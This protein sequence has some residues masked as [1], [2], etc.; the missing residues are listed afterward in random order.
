MCDILAKAACEDDV[1]CK[2]EDAEACTINELRT[3][4]DEGERYRDIRLQITDNCPDELHLQI[5]GRYNLADIKIL[6][7]LFA[8]F[9]ARVTIAW[10]RG[11]LSM[12]PSEQRVYPHFGKADTK[13]MVASY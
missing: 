9:G 8:S 6:S 7:F 13:D 1:R 2:P 4:V 5:I 12:Q 10:R 3:V 11:V